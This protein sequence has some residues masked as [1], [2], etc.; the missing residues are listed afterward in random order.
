ML[1]QAK[2][3]TLPLDNTE[4]DYIQF[5]SG[6][7]HLIMIP[8]LGEGLQSIK[9]TALP[10]SIMYRKLAGDYRVT[11]FARRKVMTPGFSTR[12]MAEDISRGMAALG[13]PTACVLGV[14]LGGM[15]VQHLAIDHPEQV[16]KLILC[17]TLPSPTQMLTDCLTGWK[18]MALAGDFS[19]IMEDTALKSYTPEK[20]KKEGTWMYR[21]MGRFI[22]PAMTDRFLIMTE[23]GLTHNAAD[24]LHAITCPTLIIGG[25]RDVIVDGRAS[26]DLHRRIPGSGLYMYPQYGH[27]LYEEALDFLERIT[28]FF[29]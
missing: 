4:M 25:E 8:G 11:V 10:F 22:K 15:I 29:E 19:G 27:G 26:Y 13:I 2:N 12:D 28:A 21:L 16:E 6:A 14:S 18:H 23:A 5:G 1:Y 20:L 9:G 24:R 17:V 7:R 3:G